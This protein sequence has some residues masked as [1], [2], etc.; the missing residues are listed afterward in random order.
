MPPELV[1]FLNSAAGVRHAF[2]VL[3]FVTLWGILA[4]ELQRAPTKAE[5]KERWDESNATY[6]RRL[7]LWRSVWPDDPNPQRVWLWT[8]E[9]V[10]GRQ[11]AKNRAQRRRLAT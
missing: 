1:R 2:R 9:Q 7:Q 4:D 6:H 10:E 5:Y 8:R 11:Q 3:E